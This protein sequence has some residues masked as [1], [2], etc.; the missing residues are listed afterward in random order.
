MQHVA[1]GRNGIDAVVGREDEEVFGVGIHHCLQH[2]Q[3]VANHCCCF[4]KHL[5]VA[6]VPEYAMV[7]VVEDPRVSDEALVEV[8]QLGPRLELQLP[9]CSAVR[10]EERV[11]MGDRAVERLVVQLC[12][13]SEEAVIV[14][15]A[16]DGK[17]APLGANV[18]HGMARFRQALQQLVA[19]DGRALVVR[20]QLPSEPRGVDCMRVLGPWHVD[21]V[22]LHVLAV[23]MDDSLRVAD[24][25]AVG[26]E[27]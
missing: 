11:R 25:K 1:T 20:R 9:S 13:A 17:E 12:A 24:R 14:L 4:I 21:G 3:V 18:P 2:L 23:P 22:E 10:E 8:H 19:F 26:D 7:Q 6:I 5:G 16:A 27:P 15:S